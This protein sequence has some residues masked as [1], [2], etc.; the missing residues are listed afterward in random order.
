[1]YRYMAPEIFEMQEYDAKADLWSVG[2]V[3]YEMLVGHPPFRGSNPRELFQ[4]IRTKPLAVP[5]EVTVGND[6]ITLLRKVWS[7]TKRLI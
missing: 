2:C 5:A 4:N 1:M 7:W 6:T 3:F